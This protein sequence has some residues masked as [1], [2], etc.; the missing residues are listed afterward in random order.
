MHSVTY[1]LTLYSS[2]LLI[3]TSLSIF[4]NLYSPLAHHSTP[5]QNLLT[6][7]SYSISLSSYQQEIMGM[8]INHVSFSMFTVLVALFSQHLVIPVISTTV[9]DPH[10][11]NPPSVFNASLCNKNLTLVFKICQIFMLAM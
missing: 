6:H 10:S 11:G 5:L 4:T 8:K 2:H 9:E 7:F 1:Q 3:F